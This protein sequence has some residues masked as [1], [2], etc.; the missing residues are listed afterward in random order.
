MDYKT[1]FIYLVF[2][3]VIAL[4]IH[5]LTKR[6]TE[7]RG[8]K[9]S[10]TAR[11]I[12]KEKGPEKNKDGED[13]LFAVFA[14]VPSKEEVRLRVRTRVFRELPEEEPGTLTYAGN[15]FISFESQNVTVVK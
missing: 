11:L 3:I 7:P 10:V 9:V 13:L 14:L 6:G 5:F 1:S 2:L 4:L 12:R 8:K 15:E